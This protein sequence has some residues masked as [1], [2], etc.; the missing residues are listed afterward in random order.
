MIIVVL[1]AYNEEECIETLLLSIK[2]SLEEERLE[3]KI[4]VVN[5]G[6]VDNTEK[7]VTEYSGKMPIELINHEKNKGLGEAIKTGFTHVARISDPD[8]I[9]ITLDADNT[10][11]PGLMYSMVRK[12]REGNDVIIASRYQHGSRIR[13]VPFYREMLSTCAAIVFRI[14]HHI[15]GVRDYTC[16]Y[17]A[18]RAS[19]IKKA[20]EVYGDQFITESGFSC[21]VDVL[22]KLRRLDLVM[23]EVPMILRYDFK[24]GESKMKI[25]KTI[26]DSLILITKRLVK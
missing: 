14:F 17:R 4:V 20:F 10:Q 24:L 11:P 15:K 12:I 18:Y 5:D 1:P 2:S 8:D 25:L 22:L 19:A 21:M 3:Y 13:G 16:G 26:R 6:S 7:I 9:I 23:N